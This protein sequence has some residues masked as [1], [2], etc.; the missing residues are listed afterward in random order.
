MGHFLAV[1]LVDAGL[2]VT[3]LGA[4]SLVRPLRFLRVATRRRASLVLAGGALLLLLGFLLPA[5]ESRVDRPQDALDR[6]VPVYQFSERHEIHVAAPPAA[7]VGRSPA[8]CGAVRLL[9]QRPST[10]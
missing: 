1:A 6:I 3:G 4:V 2:A 9:A 5:P 8:H 7:A 10:W